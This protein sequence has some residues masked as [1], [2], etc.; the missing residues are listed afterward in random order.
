MRYELF[1]AIP[2]RGQW[3]WKKERAVRAVENYRKFENEFKN[4]I[5]AE[6]YQ[7]LTREELELI[8]NK[9]LL[10]YWMSNGKPLEFIRMRGTVQY[11][12]CWVKPRE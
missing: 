4:N 3:K 1:G 9:H 12:G 2:S 10:G 6:E 7:K 5:T 8:K 11:P